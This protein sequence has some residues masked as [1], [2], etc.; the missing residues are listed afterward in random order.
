MTSTLW[1]EGIPILNYC[2][3]IDGTLCSNTEGDYLR[4]EPYPEVIARI[5][6]L[7]EA[8]DQIVLYTARGSKTGIDW[9]AVTERQL[10]EWRVRYHILCMGKPAADVYVDDKGINSVDWKRSGFQ[11]S[12]PSLPGLNG[13]GAHG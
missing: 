11:V 4:A 3:D 2:F 6:R 1:S 10:R 12:L 5:N 8:G 13:G 7:Y 9:R